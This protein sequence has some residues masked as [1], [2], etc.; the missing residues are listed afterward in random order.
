MPDLPVKIYFINPTEIKI[1]KGNYYTSTYISVIDQLNR[2]T[3][4][5]TILALIARPNG[6]TP[7]VTHL[8]YTLQYMG[9]RSFFFLFAPGKGKSEKRDL[10]N[11]LTIRYFD[12][13][14][15]LPTKTPPP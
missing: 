13:V 14:E 7:S 12:T 9:N 2:S 4:H 8:E 1:M 6:G 11:R 3:I 15:F 5:E 10:D